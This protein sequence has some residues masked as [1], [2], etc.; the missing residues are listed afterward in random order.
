[1][2][3]AAAPLQRLPG[4]EEPADKKS[5]SA[6][7]KP[8]AQTTT[9]P[10]APRGRTARGARTAFATSP[11]SDRVPT[12]VSHAAQPPQCRPRR[13]SPEAPNCYPLTARRTPTNR[14]D[15]ASVSSGSDR[16]PSWPQKSVEAAPQVLWRSRLAAGA[17]PAVRKI[18]RNRTPPREQPATARPPT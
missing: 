14:E 16:L 8:D 13:K 7:E 11:N 9:Q 10:S 18:V 4:S 1:M 12:T 3:C 2:R 6:P 17:W 5:C 15:P